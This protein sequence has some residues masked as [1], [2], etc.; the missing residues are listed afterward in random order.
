MYTA[1]PER[2]IPGKRFYLK[3]YPRDGSL[4]QGFSVLTNARRDIDQ[5]ADGETTEFAASTNTRTMVHVTQ[6]AGGHKADL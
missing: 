1:L 3:S 5:G 2:S 6:A 4:R